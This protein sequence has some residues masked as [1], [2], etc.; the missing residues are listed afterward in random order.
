MA[1]NEKDIIFEYALEQG[2]VTR[3]EVEELIGA[4]PTKAFKLLKELCSDGKMHTEGSGKQ[5]KYVPN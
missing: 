2:G 1:Q 3:K 4:G 5:S